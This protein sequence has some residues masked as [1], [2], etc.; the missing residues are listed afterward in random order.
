MNANDF[1]K[2]NF[3][4][5]QELLDSPALRGVLDTVNRHVVTEEVRSVLETLR[6]EL[7]A[8]TAKWSEVRV[9]TAQEVAERVA[10]WIRGG[11][12]DRLGAVI[13][14]T[15]V[16]LPAALGRAPLAD[17]ALEAMVETGRSYC[18]LELDLSSGLPVDR[19][20]VVGALLCQLTGA[21]GALVVNNSAAATL[22]A[23]AAVAGG[24]ELLVS[25]GQLIEFDSG[26]RIPDIVAAAGARLREVGTTNSTRLSDFE[27]AA[28]DATAAVMRVHTLNY[29]IDGATA[30]VSLEDLV[31]MARRRNLLV[32]DNLGSGTLVDLSASGLSAEPQ[33][34]TSVRAGADLVLL[35]GD[36]LIGGPQ[37][38][39]IVGRKALIDQL[40]RHPLARALRVD[41]L[42]LAALAA[43]L[44]LYLQPAGPENSVPVL[45]LLGTSAENLRHRAEKMAVQLR[46]LPCVRT[47]EAVSD[48]T[49]LGDAAV[50]GHQLATWCVAIEPAGMAASD[51]AGR[52]R[53]GRPAVCGRVV[54]DRLLLDLRA[55]RPAED[56]QIVLALESIPPAG[57]HPKSSA[58]S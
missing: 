47:V 37:A 35:S 28:G 8:K 12:S 25:R 5:V 29:V 2:K 45:A 53:S 46:G 20:Q 7:I 54:H 27:Q 58:T 39:I 6:S 50:P 1:L 42:T 15:G 24:R 36:M 22:L 23:T 17:A 57:D 13:N 4:S 38:G 56:G 34:T 40:A 44:R 32:I 49:Y 19:Q 52:L 48:H 31:A 10:Q 21:E 41:K 11:Q 33:V 3:P 14:A 26:Y 43:T 16:V 55:V 51:L 18:S 30:E 9:P